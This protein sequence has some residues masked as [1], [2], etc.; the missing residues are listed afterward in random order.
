MTCFSRARYLRHPV[1]GPRL[2]EISRE[3]LNLT[4]SDANSIFGSP[5][6][7]K[8]RSCMTL[9]SALPHTDSVFRA[10]L[11]KYFKDIPDSQTLRILGKNN[12]DWVA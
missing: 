1:L 9:F 6:D 7:L 10:V 2:L 8:L 11:N 4:T 3:L 5:D 12:S